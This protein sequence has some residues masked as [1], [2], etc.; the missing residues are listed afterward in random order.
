[1][2]PADFVEELASFHFANAFNPYADAC[3][4][5][6]AKDAPAVRRRNLEAVLNAAIERGFSPSGLLEI[7]AI[8]VAA[9]RVWH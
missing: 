6:D 9:E 8:G 3:P 2:K 4:E 1:M 7:L 5:C